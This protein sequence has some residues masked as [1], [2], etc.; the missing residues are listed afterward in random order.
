MQTPLRK[1]FGA[2]LL[3][4]ALFI[5]LC[6]LPGRAAATSGGA[7]VADADT[8]NSYMENLGGADSTLL[9]GRI[10][11]DKSVS[12]ESLTFT[13]DAGSIAVEN[14]ADFLV[15][16][17]ALATSTQLIQETT[18]PVDI[19]FILDFSAS[20]AWGQYENGAGTVTDQAGSRVQAMV[21]A[22]N[23]AIGALVAADPRSRVGIVCFNRGA[24]TMLELTAVTPRPDGDYLEITRWNATPGADDGNRGNVQVTCNI[25]STTLPLDS[26]TNIHAGLFAGMQ[27][28]ARA[29]DLTVEINGE[30]VTRV[31]NVILMS[32]GAPTTFS[33]ASGGG[34]W[35]GITN[36]P[37]GTGDNSNPHSGNGFLPL[38]TAGY[39]K[40]AIT[41]HYYPN[42]AEGQAARVYTIG[43][44]TSQQSAGM[45]AMADLVLNPAAHWNAQNAYTATGVPQVDAVNTAWQ[46]YHA[47]G[48][49]DVQYTTSQGPQNYAVDQAPGGAPAS[50]RYNDAYY[51]ADDADDLWNAFNQIINS[52]TSAAKGPTEVTDNDPVHSGYILYNDPLGPYMELKSLQ[53]VIWA[54]VEFRLEDG[55]APAAEPQPDGTTRWVY[56]G[57]LETADG[58]KTFD[59]P[60]YGRGN[61][62]DILVTVNQDAGG[63]QTL[64]VAVPAS[65]IPIRVNSITLD[66]D[67]TPIDNVS[68]NAYPLRLC[69]TVGLKDGVLNPDG[70]L[71]TNT[72]SGGVSGEYLAAHTDDATHQVYFYS[73]LYT[74]NALDGETVG[75]ATVEFNPAST[76]PFYYIQEDTPLYTDPDCT[77]RAD[78]ASFDPNLYYYFQDTY[79]AGA[80]SSVTARTYVIRRLGANLQNSVARDG[81]GWYIRA[82]A[83]RIGNLADLVRPKGEGNLTDTADTTCYPTY[84]SGSLPDSWVLAYQGNNGRL[85]LAAPASLTIAKTVTADAGLTVPAGQSF[86]FT[87]TVPGKAGQT[88]TVTRRQNGTS[89]QEQLALDGSGSAGFTLQAG[90]SLTVPD[91]QNSGFT[92]VEDPADL[93]DGFVLESAAADPADIGSFDAGTGTYTGTVGADAALLTFT[94]SY[95]AQF[96]AGAG[97]VRV[98]VTKELTGFRTDWQEGESYTF[99]IAPSDR[100]DNNPNAAIPLTADTL[101]LSGAVPTGDFVLDFARLLDAD[102]LAV[103]RAR[104]AEASIPATAESAATG[105]TAAAQ[106]PAP[107][108][109]ESA[110]G[111]GNGG[112]SDP[113]GEEAAP[114]PRPAQTPAASPMPAPGTGAGDAALQEGGATAETARRGA[115]RPRQPLLTAAQAA[116]L[117]PD[118]ARAVVGSLTG[119]YYYT[120]T[121]SGS[122][123]DMA[124]RGVTKDQSRYEVAVT[125]TDDGAGQLQAAL[126]SITRIAGPDGAIL[127]APEPAAAADFVNTTTPPAATPS[128]APGSTATPA[129]TTGTP[130]APRQAIPQT[131]DALPVGW[132]AAAAAAAAAGLGGAVWLRRRRR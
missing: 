107:A 8:R 108:T 29:T 114:S 51:P 11:S 89:S 109:G 67:G 3:A 92:V 123:A 35:Q 117:T 60:V 131:G 9:D 45:S 97:T 91:M 25:N 78:A 58:G 56:T 10:W 103:L 64:R 24:Q 95:R 87:L 22:V 26:Y 2:V 62:D 128:P 23:N 81:S 85:A 98:P 70:T 15:T 34:W 52:I 44:M 110:R 116:E 36:T 77:V 55:F 75:N 115:P 59:S 12:T 69:Y 27:M 126:D 79:Y 57:H 73:N 48:T 54:G 88:L 122:A 28:L 102:T 47:G 80:G 105:E 84:Q 17:S 132:L 1:K 43:F 18:A 71:N 41:D 37:I 129:P 4:A 38:V 30:D 86:A 6:P 100:A 66:E 118:Q 7:R 94:N 90:E 93:P 120:I 76:N 125:V 61:I 124:G 101:T 19:V 72:A 83:P 74:G 104:M 40:Q 46:D 49:P 16:Y 13:G 53:A 106:T 32:D 121:E 96:P 20:M 50:V 31:P 113:E 39:L 82:D 127:P 5:G 14:D 63:M 99:A 112:A 119:T 21:D 65:A 33:A 42:P 68:N 130:S 111:A